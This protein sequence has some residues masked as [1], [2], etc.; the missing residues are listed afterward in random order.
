ML[1]LP[2]PPDDSRNSS[3]Y[4]MHRNH[5]NH[6]GDRGEQHPWV[7]SIKNLCAIAIGW[8]DKAL[9]KINSRDGPRKF[10]DIYDESLLEVENDGGFNEQGC[11]FINISYVPYSYEKSPDSLSLSH[12]T[13][14]K[15]FNPFMLTVP[16]VFERVVIDAYVYHKYCR[17]CC[18]C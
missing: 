17:S 7:E 13:P 4:P 8:V 2:K 14:H 3:R 11:Y 5:Q 15:I 18:G 9:D 16:K 1:S 12:T 6:I 10:L